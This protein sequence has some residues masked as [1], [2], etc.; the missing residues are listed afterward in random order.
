MLDRMT[1]DYAD[2][3]KRPEWY[4]RRKVIFERDGFLCRKCSES[5]Y[6]R[7]LQVH[8]LRY[9]LGL[10]PWEYDEQE[11]ITLCVGCH[12]KTHATSKIPVFDESGNLVS[13]S[14]SMS[15]QRGPNKGV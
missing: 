8:H 5:G 15:C 11:L 12:K 10:A 6:D 2:L 9:R 13:V 7:Q 14:Q 1:P 3:L 4:A